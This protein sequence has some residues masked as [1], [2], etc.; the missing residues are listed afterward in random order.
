MLRNIIITAYRNLIRHKSYSIINIAGLTVG[1]TGCLMI[2]LYINDELSFDRYH[3]NLEKMYRVVHHYS[4]DEKGVVPGPSEYQVWGNAPIGPALEADF[5]EVDKV[6]QFSGQTSLL[7][8]YGDLRFQ[9]D[10]VFYADSTVF[11]VFSWNLIEGSPSEALAGPDRVVLTR[12]LARK[13]FGAESAVGKTLVLDHTGSLLVSG[14]MEDVPTNS[15][16]RFDAL[17]SMATF[18]HSRPE[19]FDYWGYVDFYTYFTVSENFNRDAFI[20]RIPA[21]LKKNVSEDEGYTW[22]IEAVKDAY[23]RSEAQRQ[24][25]VVGSL[26]NLYVFGTVAIFLLVTAC[27][28]FI[29]LSTARSMDRAREVGVR[30][31]L[32]AKETGLIRQF[33]SESVLLSCLAT[34]LALCLTGVL[35]PYFQQLS[36]K[37]IAIKPFL[38]GEYAGLLL[39]SSVVVGVIAG[40]YPAVVLTRFKPALVL[41]G[42]FR[43]SSHGSGVRKALVVFQFSLSVALI[44]G[45]ILV[46][47]QLD[48]LRK[49]GLGFTQQQMLIIE[50]NWDVKV[51]NEIN[52]V[53][54]HLSKVPGVAALSAQR[55]VP[56]GFFPKAYT[57]IEAADGKMRP[58]DLNLYEVDYDFIANFELEVVAGRPYSLDFPSDSLKAMVINESAARLA[59]YADPRQVIGKKFS[60]WGKEG[61]V[62]GVVKDFNYTSLHSTIEPLTLRL[63]PQYSTSSISLRLESANLPETIARVEKAWAEVVP[64]R[65]F[66]Y[67]FLDESFNRQYN[68]DS[69]FA[70]VFTIFAGLAIFIA[71][72]GLYGLATYTVEQ[73]TKEIGIRKVMGASAGSIIS[74]L[75]SDFVKLVFVSIAIAVPFSWYFMNQWLSGFAY[76]ISPGWFIFVGSGMLVMIIALMIVCGQAIRST[77]MNPVKALRNE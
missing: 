70:N 72:F 8:E 37:E 39:A 11:D 57:E 25:G 65:P 48:H 52:T 38:T 27:I 49:H 31:T 47:S 34:F 74:M 1:I 69:R 71:C 60:Q 7:F 18:R 40:F 55:T 77:M 54:T 76:H 19:I 53:K 13:Y 56:G 66:D 24:P 64:F 36:G 10:N 67:S 51:Q 16:F 17:V 73:R 28:N 41:K 75:S 26:A 44:A 15:H 68:S 46:F 6:V 61:M 43:A 5:S 32:G 14:V 9:E 4:H 33:L 35:L 59:G 42:L 45:A 29:N 3:T 62:V 20:S 50:F 58:F 22:T 21:F 30:K 23:L 12:S 63:S 2:A